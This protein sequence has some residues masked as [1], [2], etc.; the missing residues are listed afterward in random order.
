MRPSLAEY[1]HV[2]SGKVRDLYEVDD[3]HLL[4]V[5]SDR[6]SAYDHVLA[7]PIPDKGRVLTALSV[8]FFER[9]AVRNHLAGPPDD[10]RIPEEV[11]GRA[12]VV[13]KLRM[14]PVECIARGYLTGSGWSDYQADG[15]VSGVALPPGLAEN[16]RLA[17]AI[18]T[19]TTKADVGEHDESISFDGVAEQVGAELA[20]QLRDATL[21]IFDAASRLVADRGLTLVDTKFE[22]GLDSDGQLVLADE[23]LT[24]DSSRYWPAESPGTSLDKQYVRNWLTSPESGWS[25]SGGAAPPPLPAEVADA[26]RER[27]IQLY[28]QV[29]GLSF[30]AWLA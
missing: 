4:F 30:G 16:A 28:E 15:S 19:P 18:F 9:L 11:L 1:P 21:E 17:P 24:P 6:L 14:V 22:F 20:E 2:H 7:T 13:R 26:T 25:K 12:L 5:A 10:G 29:T 27:Y 3:E 23:A 8:F